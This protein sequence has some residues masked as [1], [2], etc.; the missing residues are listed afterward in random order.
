MRE[1]L[2]VHP[3]ILYEVYEGT[4]LV[5]FKGHIQVDWFLYK[6]VSVFVCYLLLI[7]LSIHFIIS[8]GTVVMDLVYIEAQPFSFKYVMEMHGFV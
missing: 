2:F 6:W 4:C 5:W 7:C 1:A 3:F 8:R